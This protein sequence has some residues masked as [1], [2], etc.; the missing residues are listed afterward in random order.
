[1]PAMYAMPYY[2]IPSPTTPVNPGG[3]PFLPGAPGGPVV[4]GSPGGLGVHPP[5][6]PGSASPS[7]MPPGS[8]SG[9]L[10]SPLPPPAPATAEARQNVKNQ[11]QAQI[12]YYFG[13]DNLIKDIYL[14]SR[15]SEE[16]WVA[17]GLLAGFRR[18]QAMTTD[19][20]IILEAITSSSKLEIDQQGANVRLKHNWE[21]WL[22]SASTAGGASPEVQVASP[23][24]RS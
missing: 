6:G 19:I 18:I 14:R 9:C 11:V 1:M 4:P 10:G 13:Q 20:T 2:V 24:G 21:D 12:E 17:I 23:A 5:G 7:G 15:M 3:G 22:L 16:G 8:P